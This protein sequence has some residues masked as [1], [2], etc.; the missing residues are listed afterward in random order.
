MDILEKLSDKFQ[1]PTD[2]LIDLN[3]IGVIA[4]DC[5]A[6]TIAE[7]K[8]R[9]ISI[10][11]HAGASVTDRVD[12]VKSILI[13]HDISISGPYKRGKREYH[14][15]TEKETI[16]FFFYDSPEV[17]T[18][19][20]FA[21]MNFQHLECGVHKGELIIKPEI[22]ELIDVRVTGNY[23]I[24]LDFPT[25]SLGFQIPFQGMIKMDFLHHI[26]QQNLGGRFTVEPCEFV[27][28]KKVAR[29]NHPKVVG[30]YKRKMALD[31]ATEI[32][33]YLESDEKIVPSLYLP[34]S[35]TIRHKR[36]DG[37]LKYEY[38]LSDPITQQLSKL[39]W[40]E[41]NVYILWGSD[42]WSCDTEPKY[43]S[44]QDFLVRIELVDG[45]LI[46]RLCMDVTGIFISPRIEIGRIL[47]LIE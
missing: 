17:D 23:S 9:H 40:A 1:L 15:F 4:G 16:L 6:T 44:K 19:M 41:Q 12:Q 37:S 35:I 7:T 14:W 32:C 24:P 34:I 26:G 47:D 31:K 27:K 28:L 25:C 29:Y 36:K 2:L 10:Y 45:E 46:G 43:G 18:S 3:D 30:L 13:K 20:I 5:V 22:Q 42:S 39:M 38:D 8:C 11:I 21:S 33:F